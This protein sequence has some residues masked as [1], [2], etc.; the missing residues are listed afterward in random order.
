MNTPHQF[1]SEELSSLKTRAART[2]P[3][4]NASCVS[5]LSNVNEH[6]RFPPRFNRYLRIMQLC[7]SGS[8][9]SISKRAAQISCYVWLRIRIGERGRHSEKRHNRKMALTESNILAT[10][11][12]QTTSER[13]N[14]QALNSM[15]KNSCGLELTA[16]PPPRLSTSSESKQLFVHRRSHLTNAL[17]KAQT[18]TIAMLVRTLCTIPITQQQQFLRSR[19]PKHLFCPGPGSSSRFSRFRR[20][21]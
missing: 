9:N 5:T 18:I 2:S 10:R 1:Q 20:N 14:S 16:F 12:A 7:W 8:S 3:R 15:S 19:T 13:A 6:H 11:E 21:D 4:P 17:I